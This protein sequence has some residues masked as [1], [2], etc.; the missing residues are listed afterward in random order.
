[1][2][3]GPVYCMPTFGGPCG[4]WNHCGANSSF[5]KN[6]F[7][8]SSIN[9]GLA[10]IVSLIQDRNN[11]VPTGQAAMN[12]AGNISNGL[13]RN[14]VAAEMQLYGNPMGNMINAM[15][16]YGNPYS[17]FIG[18]T[19]LMT[20]CSPAMYFGC[21]PYMTPFCSPFGGFYC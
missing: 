17:N 14:A 16:G 20:A 18:T 11:G 5:A 21:V 9:C 1:M 7:T 15:A 10:S 4:G 12:F 19:A 3:W 2:I 6:M 8:W 13:G